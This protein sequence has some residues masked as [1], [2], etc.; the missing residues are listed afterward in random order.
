MSNNAIM[1]NY[2]TSDTYIIQYDCVILY[3][4]EIKS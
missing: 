4:S 1:Y 3:N 2:I